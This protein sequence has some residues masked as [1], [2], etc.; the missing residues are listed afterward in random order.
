MAFGT[1]AISIIY[2]FLLKWLTKPLLYLSMMA[3]LIGFVLL[4]GWNWLKRSEYDP[5]AESKNYRFST[6][7]AITAWVVGFLYFLFISCCWNNIKVG[8]AIVEAASEFVT[9]NLRILIV[10][11]ISFFIFVSYIA[12]WLITAV[13]LYS[14]GEPEFE[15]NAFFANIKWKDDTRNSW[16]F[17]LFGV[18]WSIAF[19]IC[20]Q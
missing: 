14:I 17:F 20:I 6:S 10:P 3:I 2:I 19:F 5:E 12:Y 7:G 4:G 15:E 8:V 16:Y 13:H 11:L 1:F 9:Q 18:C